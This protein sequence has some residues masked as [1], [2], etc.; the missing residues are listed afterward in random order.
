MNKNND[1]ALVRKPS[2]AV[3]KAAPGAKRILSSMVADA[4][5]LAQEE[6]Y[7][8]IIHVDDEDW[9]LEIVRL[10]IR[11]N[12]AFKNVSVQEFQNRDEAWREL[13]RA[14]PDL[15][16]TDLRSDNV[17]I[18]RQSFGMSGLEM[19]SLLAK[20]KVKYPILVYSGSLAIE[21]YEGTARQA[22]GSNLNVS[23]L[24]KPATQEQLC[25]ELSKHLNQ[26]WL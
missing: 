13:L 15:L 7:F 22:A 12:A 18:P 6:K 9:L 20:K 2:S 17:P 21:G 14:D 16:I 10:T 3:E 26:A 1:F 24:T 11:S 8:R 23:F 25:S 5:T 4:L 19:L